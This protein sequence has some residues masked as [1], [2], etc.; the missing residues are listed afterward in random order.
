M[1][2]WGGQTQDGSEDDGIK[3]ANC[4]E[5]FDPY[6]EVWSQ[7]NTAGTPHPGLES[8]A[9]AS[10][11]ELVYMYGG[12]KSRYEGVLSCFNVKSLTW[13]QLSPEGGTAGRP[14]RKI[15]CGMVHFHH[16]KL[17]VI[18]GYGYPTGPTQSGSSFIRNTRFTDG[19]R[20]TNEIHVFDLSQGIVTQ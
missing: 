3:L 20:W 16:D 17:A 14:M 13:L 5:Q 19:R 9:C 15:Y 18:G 4:I 2:L 1:H 11:G 12:A 7:L 6:L 10:S 8:A